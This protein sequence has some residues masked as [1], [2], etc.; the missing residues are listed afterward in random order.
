MQSIIR[1]LLLTFIPFLALFAERA[2]VRV[3]L[4]PRW[5]ETA[6]RAQ[7]IRPVSP[8][9]D[10]YWIVSVDS[11]HA[12]A[13]EAKNQL[14]PRAKLHQELRGGNRPAWIQSK[15]RGDDMLDLIVSFH[16]DVS[17]DEAQAELDRIGAQI[18]D[19]SEYFERLTIRLRDADLEEIVKWDWVRFV[20]PGYAPY[21]LWNNSQSAI[22]LKVDV[23]QNE[24]ALDGAGTRVAVIDGLV[25]THPEFGDRLK[26]V[27]TGTPDGHGTHVAGTLA[28]AGN[29]DPRIK[30]MAPAARISSFSFLTTNA[31]IAANLAAKQLEG[32]DLAQNSWGAVT[33]ELFGTCGLM[34][35]YTSFDRDIDRIVADEKFPIV[36][37]VGN[38]RNQYDCAMFARAGFYTLP[39]PGTSKNAILVGAVDRENTT[40]SFSSFGP[41][42]DGRLKPDLVALGVSVLSTSLRNATATLSGTS[43][44][45]P[46]VSGLAA[47]LIDRFR[48][49]NGRAPEPELLRGIL[50]NTANDLGNPGPDY[51]YGFGIPDGLK[52]VGIID[53]STWR[54][55]S[56]QAGE[57]KE[58]EIDVPGG[59]EALRVMLAWTDPPASLTSVRQ[60]VND[61][62][63]EL[64]APDGTVHQPFVLNPLRAE[65]DATRGENN[66]DN[67]EQAALNQPSGGVWKA[68]IR[69]KS[70]LAAA[71]AFAL[72]WTTAANPAPACSTNVFPAGVTVLETEQ[73]FTVQ[74]AR[75]SVCEPWTA[76]TTASW[77]KPG[78]PSPNTASGLV[79]LRMEPNES[80]AQRQGIVNIAG[81]NFT[82]R[83][84]T[85][86]IATPITPGVPVSS[87]LAATDCFQEGEFGIY[88]KLFTFTARAGQRLEATQTSSR[89]DSF[90]I[91]KGPGGNI[92]AEDDD[93]GGGLNSRIPASGSLTLPISG[94]YTLVA[95]SFGANEVG[96]F[97]LTV[98]LSEGDGNT[99]ALPKVVPNCPAE[100]TGQLTASSSRDGR[101]GDLHYTD[102]YLLEGRIG[103][104]LDIAVP[105]ANFDAVLYLIAPNGTQIA[106]SDDTG[107]SNRPG[108]QR[109]LTASGPYRLEITSFSPF[110]SGTYKIQAQGCTESP[111]Q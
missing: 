57:S 86:C 20:E 10:G 32:A 16:R 22:Q 71:Q 5:N 46:A 15:F 95:T 93:S 56:L 3:A 28:A 12:L 94:T 6:L 2:H 21:G 8:D 35:L 23:L 54:T 110:V 61:L 92:I 104:V 99:D 26:Q 74:V 49:K 42:R 48:Q 66:L 30:G 50:L 45:A 68:R 75:A 105:E 53:N 87:S 64:V 43:M 13:K 100:L 78:E 111:N 36:F 18:M 81:R 59:A 107:D 69:G 40:S 72:T 90:L 60:L 102:I 96:P 1:A 24:M 14:D 9:G 91:L 109:T 37:A 88:S 77:I 106:F 25:D 27:R 31:G 83:Q 65:A 34:G 41:T 97:T 82:V 52:A 29:S 17:A 70:T 38:T 67:V 84:N 79:K 19:R 89:F 103:Q 101:R 76:T 108:V 85:K 58:I 33:S 51:S 11:T 98:T 62:D 80:G 4:G 55:D 44:S 7:G 39:P 47:L 73:L 63:L